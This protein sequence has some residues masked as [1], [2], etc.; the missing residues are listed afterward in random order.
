MPYSDSQR[1]C[2]RSR[3]ELNSGRRPATRYSRDHACHTSG[4]ATA[5]S[6]QAS[7]HANSAWTKRKTGGSCRARDPAIA[8]PPWSIK[9][10]ENV[11]AWFRLSGSGRLDLLPTGKQPSDR[12]HCW[13]GRRQQ[14]TLT[15]T[16]TEPS[17]QHHPKTSQIRENSVHK[18]VHKEAQKKMPS[19]LSRRAF[20]Q[21]KLYFL[22][23]SG[24]RIRTCDLW[25]MSPASY[26]AAP[27]RD[28]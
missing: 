22:V 12:R 6:A 5:V 7:S 26:R 3:S 13:R 20:A 17:G 27:P 4:S 23:S 25:V 11:R 8:G 15:S 18:S 10:T 14:T 21:F 2:G 16:D 1:H 19:E 24:D 28:G 9:S